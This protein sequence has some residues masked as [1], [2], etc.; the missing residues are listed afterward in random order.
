MNQNDENQQYWDQ[1]E[2]LNR[3]YEDDEFMDDLYD[4]DVV[5]NEPPKED[6]LLDDHEDMDDIVK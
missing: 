1:K 6:L 4:L 3:D 5:P 2:V